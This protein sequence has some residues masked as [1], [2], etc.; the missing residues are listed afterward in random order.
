MRAEESKVPNHP[1]VHPKGH[2][3]HPVT[4]PNPTQ[5]GYVYVSTQACANVKAAILRLNELFSFSGPSLTPEMT[6]RFVV[7][8]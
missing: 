2:H 4:K 5:S 7:L 6:P 8:Y 3:S 1:K